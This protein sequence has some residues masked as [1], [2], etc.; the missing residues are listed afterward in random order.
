MCYYTP[1]SIDINRLLLTNFDF[2]ELNYNLTIAFA[3]LGYFL[4]AILSTY[5]V[6]FWRKTPYLLSTVLSVYIFH[7]ITLCPGSSEKGSTYA[8]LKPEPYHEGI[9]GDSWLAATAFSFVIVQFVRLDNILI[10]F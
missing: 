10:N 1:G 6:E 4:F 9:N 7:L 5:P 3:L 8:L 2:Y